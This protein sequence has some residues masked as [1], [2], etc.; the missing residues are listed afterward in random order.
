MKKKIKQ[1][2]GEMLLLVQFSDF[3]S[4]MISRPASATG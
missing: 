1:Q 2:V 3:S 4:H